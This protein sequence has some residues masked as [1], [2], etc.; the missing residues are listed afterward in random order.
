MDKIL[1]SQRRMPPRI[2]GGGRGQA[3][4]GRGPAVRDVFGDAPRAPRVQNRRQK[5]DVLGRFLKVT[6]ATFEEEYDPESASR[7]LKEVM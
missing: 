7:W 2:R 3:D 5:D 1:Y 4:A 6:P